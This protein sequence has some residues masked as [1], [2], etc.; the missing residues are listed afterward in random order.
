MGFNILKLLSYGIP[1]KSYFGEMDKVLIVTTML[2]FIFYEG[3]LGIIFKKVHTFWSF[4]ISTPYTPCTLYLGLYKIIEFE[5]L[6][7]KNV[8]KPS[9]RGKFSYQKWCRA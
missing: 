4:F 1:Q 7:F 5:K 3:V 6:T 9:K 2:T 8:N